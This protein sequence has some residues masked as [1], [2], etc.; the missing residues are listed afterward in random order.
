MEILRKIVVLCGAWGEE[1]GIRSAHSRRIVPSRER[2]II[3]A[4]SRRNHAKGVYIIRNLLRISSTA[5]RC[6]SSSRRKI[7]A[8]RDEIQGR[9]A[10]LD[11]IHDYVVIICQACGLDKQKRTFGR[12]KFL[13]C[14]AERE[15]FALEFF[16]TFHSV[17]LLCF[18]KFFGHRSKTTHR[19]VFSLRSN[20]Y[21]ILAQRKKHRNCGAFSLWR[22]ERDSN[23]RNGI[24]VHTIS[25]RAP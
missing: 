3:F 19:V 11:D 1:R 23:P 20:P 12:Q 13:F 24:S 8:G 2:G 15:G 6:I 9:L 17:Y 10:A 22:R 4:H 5:C 14:W 16:K 7:H 21:Y 25:N 18:E